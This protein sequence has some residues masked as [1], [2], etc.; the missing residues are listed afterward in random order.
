MDRSTRKASSRSAIS[1]LYFASIEDSSEPLAR[2]TLSAFSRAN[3]SSRLSF[4]TSSLLPPVIRSFSWRALSLSRIISASSR[5]FVLISRSSFSLLS[6]ASCADA[7][8]SWTLLNFCSSS[9]CSC[10]NCEYNFARASYFVRHVLTCSWSARIWSSLEEFCWLKLLFS[11][12]SWFSR[13]FILRSYCSSISWSCSYCARALRFC[14]SNS[15]IRPC[16]WA[17]YCSLIS[18]SWASR[19]CSSCNRRCSSKSRSACCCANCC[20]Y[21]CWFHWSCNRRCSASYSSCCLRCSFFQNSLIGSGSGALPGGG[22]LGGADSSFFST[23]L[24]GR[25]GKAGRSSSSPKRLGGSCGSL[26]TWI[27][28]VKYRR[29]EH[30]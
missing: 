19:C 24:V 9:R 16:V 20:W 10:R 2:S 28:L 7:A 23:S 6:I 21:C 18:C 25:R 4:S 29:F 26:G 17:W 15:A 22:D 11:W 27:R 1:R 3:R 8:L 5:F 30:S 14:C 13:S 12:F